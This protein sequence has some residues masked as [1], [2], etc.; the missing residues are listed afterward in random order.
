MNKKKLAYSKPNVEF[1]D[2]TLSSNIAAN[3]SQIATT[4]DVNTCFY[5]ENGLIVFVTTDSGC[6]FPTGNSEDNF[7][8]HVPF[9]DKRI[10]AS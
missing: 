5:E 10:F 7:C 1:V 2:F 9:D 3:C 6:T 8:Y 4:S